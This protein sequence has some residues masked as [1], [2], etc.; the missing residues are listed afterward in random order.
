MFSLYRKNTRLTFICSKS[1]IE[2]LHIGVKHICSELH[3]NDV[4]HSGVFIGNSE[5]TYFTQFFSVSIVDFEQ[6]NI[7][8]AET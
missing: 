3:Q 6:V 7:S 4:S 2:T 1:T 8:W 5:H